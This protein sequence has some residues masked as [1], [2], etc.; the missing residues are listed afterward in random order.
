MSCMPFLRRHILIYGF[1]GWE[2]AGIRRPYTR[3]DLV[4]A[5]R[6]VTAAL[7]IGI[8]VFDHADIYRSAQLRQSRSR[9]R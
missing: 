8:R 4:I 3:A 7:E 6:A 2:G 5:E 9:F 1:M